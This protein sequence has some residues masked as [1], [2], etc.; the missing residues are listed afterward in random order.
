[1][2]GFV[3]ARDYQKVCQ[4]ICPVA[5]TRSPG[6]HKNHSV[7]RYKGSFRVAARYPEAA[8]RGN[9]PARRRSGHTRL[10]DAQARPGAGDE[11]HAGK[12]DDQLISFVDFAP[13]TLAL[14][15]IDVPQHMHGRDFIGDTNT[16]TPPKE[17]TYIHAAADRF[18]GFTDTTVIHG[19]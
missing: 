1:M 10:A 5:L 19:Y 6:W 17:R 7:K 8:A 11:L 12:R 9:G 15:G 18:D 13:T 4:S 2:I 3:D 14:A 16:L